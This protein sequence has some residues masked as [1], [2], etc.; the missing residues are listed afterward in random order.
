MSDGLQVTITNDTV[1]P[2]LARLKALGRSTRPVVLAMGNTLQSITEGNFNT[3]GAAFRPSVWKE[4]R[5]G[6][7]SIQQSRNPLLSRSFHLEIN[8]DSARLSNPTPTPP[9]TSFKD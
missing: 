1:T 9:S 3:A 8:E 5:D 4:K 6:S 7:P 2:A